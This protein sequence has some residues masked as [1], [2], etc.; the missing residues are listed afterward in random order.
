[1]TFLDRVVKMLLPRE[2]GFF[3]LLERGAECAKESGALMAQICVTKNG[4]RD[5]LLK[6]L[7][8]VEHK[9]DAVI[10]ETYDALNTPS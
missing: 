3:D 10:H 4:V 8:D 2:E 6:Q 1:M 5:N 7:R 9:A